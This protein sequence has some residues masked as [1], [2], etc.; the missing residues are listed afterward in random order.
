MS[1]SNTL[2]MGVGNILM[3]DEGIGVR[4]VESL[5][6]DYQL[7][8]NVEVLDGGT[9]GMDLLG[10]VADR[11]ELVIADAVNSRRPPGSMVVLRDDE[12]RALFRS[13]I[14]P[15]QL[16][17]SDLLAALALMDAA[18]RRLVLVGVVPEAMET[19]LE[20]TATVA[21]ARNEAVARLADELTRLGHDVAPRDNAAQSA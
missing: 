14:S 1:E 4:M 10:T 9:A 16:G 20:L 8:A 21:A 2:V 3:Q 6:A 7:P 17:I 13:K 19:G 18:P 11:D 12:V 15:H 5:Q